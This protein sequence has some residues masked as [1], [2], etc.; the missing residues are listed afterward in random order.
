MTDTSVRIATGFPEGRSEKLVPL[1]DIETNN[2]NSIQQKYS[3][4][5]D[6]RVRADGVSQYIILDQPSKFQHFQEDPWITPEIL[7][8]TPCMQDGFRVKYL[9]IGAGYAGLCFA[10]RLIEAGIMGDE[11]YMVDSAGGYGGTWYWNRYPGLMC[12]TESYIYMPL[13]EEMGY[14]PKHKYAYGTELRAHAESIADRWNLRT[15]TLFAHETK[16]MVWNETRNK[17]NVEMIKKGGKEGFTID[18]Q[19]V[20]LT[21]GLLTIPKIPDLQ[22]IED[23]EGHCFHTSRWDY[24]YTGGSPED[25]NLFKL[26]DKRVGIIGTGATAVQAIPELAKWAKDL[27]VFQRTPSAVDTRGQ[28][29]TDPS[30]WTTKVATGED[31]QVKRGQNFNTLVSQIKPPPPIDLV[32]DQWTKILTYHCFIGAPHSLT[33]ETLPAYLKDLNTADIPR[34]SRI[35]ARVSEIVRNEKTAEALKAWYPSW[36]KR[37]CFHDDY[38]PTFNQENVH[39]VDTAGRGVDRFD[40][41]GVVVGGVSYPLDVLIFSTGYKSPGIGSPASK[42]GMKILGRGGLDMDDKHE[43]GVASLHGVAFSGF[44]NFWYP[45]LRQGGASANWTF[46]LNEYA[47]HVAHIVSSVVEREKSPGTAVVEVSRKAEEEWVGEILKRVGGI[48]AIIGC[49]PSYLNQ[50]GDIERVA[51][52]KAAK[53]A[54]ASSWGYGVGD[55]VRVIEAWREEGSLRGLEI[56]GVS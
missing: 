54:Q 10:V 3:E 12:D 44:P 17:W 33:Q 5:R 24:S 6:K 47:K 45:G 43:S 53:G 22:G 31:W 18:A 29:A 37:P 11:I 42:S 28:Q 36:C 55:F 20:F 8:S 50:E 14:M 23:F 15:N 19:F 51:P 13:L 27:Y 25:P 1:H 38:L 41:S 9:I 32:D 56:S 4:E 40:A 48:A 49:T 7:N 30:L 35:R 2:I 39:L 21:T 26:K 34:Q 16:K 46:I 52:E